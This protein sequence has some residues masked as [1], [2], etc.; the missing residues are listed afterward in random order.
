MSF[1]PKAANKS[2]GNYVRD[3]NQKFPTP[4]AGNRKARVSL[5][6]DLGIQERK[7]FVDPKT[8][9]EK[10]QAPAQQ[11]AICLDLTHDVVDYGGEI[12]KQPY[13]LLLNKTYDGELE[14]INFAPVPPRNADGQLIEGKAWTYHPASP[15]TKLA[16]ATGTDKILSGED[17]DLEQLLGKPLMVEVEVKERESKDKK[18]ENGKP[19]VFT[20]VGYKGVSSIPL[21]DDDQPVPVNPCAI[22]PRIITFDDAT[23]EDVK[24]IRRDILRK[25][26]LAQDYV[27]SQMQK[28][29]E[30][31]EAKLASK[32][33]KEEPKQEAE[34]KK[35]VKKPVK[36]QPEPQ[37]EENVTDPEF[38]DDLP[39]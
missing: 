16:R 8:K 21:D 18:D 19:V 28:A 15:L 13:R 34:Q 11:I 23:E 1:K 6:I 25:I 14:G 32:Q 26:K 20:N 7:P 33:K 12:G 4:K 5:I 2:S 22:E 30:A 31:Y 9:E 35:E 29:V 36:K 3:P 38:D 39:F 10:P 17:L 37:A 24:F 27:G